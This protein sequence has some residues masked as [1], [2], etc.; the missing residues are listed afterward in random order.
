MRVISS[1]MGPAFTDLS[2]DVATDR[3]TIELFLRNSLRFI[4][5]CPLIKG[6]CGFLRVGCRCVGSHCGAQ[7]R[8][9]QQAP[10][11][12]S[13]CNVIDKVY[14]AVKN[15]NASSVSA[16][17]DLAGVDPVKF[18]EIAVCDSDA[19]RRLRVEFLS[20]RGIATRSRESAR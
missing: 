14:S 10:F 3:P 16:C 9:L 8:W 1:T 7:I 12:V 17:P 20:N 2:S 18:I 15:Y 13:S 6:G 4:V 19:R 11:L 5:A